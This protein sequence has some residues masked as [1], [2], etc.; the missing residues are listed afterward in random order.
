MLVVAALVAAEAAAVLRAPATEAAGY[1]E[2]ADAPSSLRAAL[3]NKTLVLWLA[4]TTFCALLDE[5][6][7]A[8]AALHLRRDLGASDG[9][10]AFALTAWAI[11]AAVG[12]FATDL[13][14]RRAHPRS[15]LVGSSM[16][17]MLA[18]AAWLRTGSPT[19]AS[20][21]VFLVGVTTA[22]LYPIAK[23]QVFAACPRRPALVGA[24]AQLFAPAEIAMPLLL[25]LLADYAGLR[26]TLASLMLQP[27]ALLVLAVAAWPRASRGVAPATR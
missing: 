4:G 6:F 22:P 5:V 11:G 12:L 9:A 24:A 8:F 2:P 14:L 25:G 10:A 21:G 3:R 1:D 18:C 13:A 27:L 26:A 20:V 17:C 16:A 15:I 23:A 7:V 19:L